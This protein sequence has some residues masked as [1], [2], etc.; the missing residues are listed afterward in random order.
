MRRTL[1]QRIRIGIVSGIR[2][3]A[4]DR[5]IHL[6]VQDRANISQA[7]PALRVQRPSQRPTP[8]VLA[9]PSGLEL[10]GDGYR[11]HK[12]KIQPFERRV[13]RLQLT[14]SLDRTSLQVPYV[15]SERS[16]LK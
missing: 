15:H 16:C 12:V 8:Q 6:D 11:A 3:G 5:R 14:D 10:T 13:V 4:E 7:P 9:R 2:I 1:K